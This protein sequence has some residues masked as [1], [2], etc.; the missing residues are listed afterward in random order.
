MFDNFQILISETA[1]SHLMMDNFNVYSKTQFCN[2][3]SKG[4]TYK[5]CIRYCLQVNSY[6]HDDGI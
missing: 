5:F 2:Q 3:I 6:K 1:F 4:S